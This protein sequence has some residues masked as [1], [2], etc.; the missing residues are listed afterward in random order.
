MFLTMIGKCV[1]GGAR[2]TAIR[3]G[4]RY[5][6]WPTPSTGGHLSRC[7]PRGNEIVQH[8]SKVGLE[9]KEYLDE[10]LQLGPARRRGTADT[11]DDG[12]SHGSR[13]EG[14]R[15]DNRTRC[16]GYTF[17]ISAERGRRQ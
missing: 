3:V 11:I 7:F 4:W 16:V 12:G 15:G 1:Q 8:E 10:V 5:V 17:Y 2:A 9:E 6:L 14:K 13:G